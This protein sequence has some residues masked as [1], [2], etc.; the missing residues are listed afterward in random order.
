MSSALWK[1]L[2]PVVKPS[3]QRGRPRVDARAALNGILF[4][5]QTGV[6]SKALGT[7]R[8]SARA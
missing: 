5:L 6:S 8:A 1:A 7:A 2:L 4:V 3:G